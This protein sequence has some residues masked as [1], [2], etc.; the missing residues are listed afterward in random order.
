MAVLWSGRFRVYYNK[1]DEFPYVWSVDMGTAE[2]E[3]KFQQVSIAVSVRG[4]ANLRSDNRTEPRAWLEGEG[5]VKQ[6][7]DMCLIGEVKEI[8]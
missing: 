5:E 8:G 7:G 2:S 6:M 1:R 3:R 4:S